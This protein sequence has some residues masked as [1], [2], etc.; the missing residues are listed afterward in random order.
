[1]ETFKE[2]SWYVLPLNPEPWAVGPLSV[3]RGQGGRFFPRM[4]QNQQLASY[5]EAVRSELRRQRATMVELGEG[6]YA[7]E[8]V[9]MFHQVLAK[10]ITASGR[11]SQQKAADLTNL[12]KA[13]EDAIQGILISNDK[14]V[15]KSTLYVQRSEAENAVPFVAI[16]V[17]PYLGLN[18][19]EL[20]VEVWDK[21]DLATIEHRK[22]THG[23]REVV[24]LHLIHGVGPD[25]D[26]P[27]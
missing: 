13:T 14:L 20:P 11:K 2:L 9:F 12:T 5:Q 21:V 23:G 6:Y 1:M 25:E 3:S 22:M 27:F 19:S 24:N 7:Y 4:G 18:P 10:Y 16:G 26:L 15:E 8:L 17:G